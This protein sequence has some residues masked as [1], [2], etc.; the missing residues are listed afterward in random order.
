METV[1]PHELSLVHFFYLLLILVDSIHFGRYRIHLMTQL[2][3]S[4]IER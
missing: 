4:Y 3:T 1:L 2:K